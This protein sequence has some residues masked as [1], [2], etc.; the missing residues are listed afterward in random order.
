MK[1][2]HSLLNSIYAKINHYSPVL[3][4]S[5]LFLVSLFFLSLTPNNNSSNGDLAM[6]LNGQMRVVQGGTP[7]KDFWTPY[8]ALESYF[9]AFIFRNFG[10]TINAV[11]YTNILISALVVLFAFIL[12]RQVTKNNMLSI[13]ASLLVLFNGLY[14]R[15][16]YYIHI[17]ILFL[18]IA[19]ILFFK[20]TALN[21]KY[22]LL[23]A[24]LFTG[25]AFL[26][27]IELAGAYGLALFFGVLVNNALN[28]KKINDS[29]KDLLGI[30]I[31]FVASLTI[32]IL[33]N[34]EVA[35]YLY[36]EMVIDALDSGT[37]MN[38]PYFHS[39]GSYAEILFDKLALLNNSSSIFNFFQ[40]G[41]FFIYFLNVALNY[42]LPFIVLPLAVIFLKKLN[43][44]KNTNLC[45]FFF[46]FWTIATFPKSLGRSAASQLSH[47]LMPL[48][49]VL[50]MTINNLRK[51]YI[52][53]KNREVLE[54]IIIYT[55]A[56]SL[57][58]S[59]VIVVS[60]SVNTL[61]KPSYEIKT[62][63]GTLLTDE[64]SVADETNKIIELV[65]NYTNGP[66]DYIFV[67]TQEA[68]PIYTLTNRK[69][70]TYYSSMF[71]VIIRPS[72]EKQNKMCNDLITKK[73]KII[74]HDAY[75]GYDDL[76]ERQF[77]F[78]ARTL[79][80]CIIAN[81]KFLGNYG[82]YQVYITYD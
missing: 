27:K 42:F 37:S 2:I 12:A 71:D 21:R 59:S 14:W 22:L 55:T 36:K 75:W 81:F 78:A 33:F 48:F 11:Y 28:G 35:P 29:A 4:C 58:L 66:E 20:Y 10:Q 43:L 47:A 18:L 3:V 72:I 5:V 67:S 57:I 6:F 74:I 53:F 34:P 26:F 52:P 7:Y 77:L 1:R 13:M 19:T 17:Y 9:P 38:L 23:L 31:G 65:Y 50:I 46:I 30:G 60:S 24:G 54:K 41:F 49:F 56:I 80:E 68:P 70:P 44:D 63:H 25:F 16:F 69:N 8:G 39:I 76:P 15:T 61:S 79:H 45:Y 73:T 82:R 32:L 51:D 64:K 40:A 62:Q